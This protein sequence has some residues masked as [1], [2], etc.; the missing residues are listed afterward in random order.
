MTKSALNAKWRHLDHR[1][2]FKLFEQQRDMIRGEFL[3]RESESRMWN[4]QNKGK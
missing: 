1:E 4:K 3:E 2:P